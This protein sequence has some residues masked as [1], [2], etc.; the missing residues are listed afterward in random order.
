MTEKCLLVELA[1]F[2][3]GFEP[4]VE[5]W[6]T[7][8]MKNTVEVGKFSSTFNFFPQ[9]PIEKFSD[10]WQNVLWIRFESCPIVSLKTRKMRQIGRDFELWPKKLTW[11]WNGKI[12]SNLLVLCPTRLRSALATLVYKRSKAKLLKIFLTTGNYSQNFQKWMLEI[13]F[14]R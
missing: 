3:N 14:Q 11:K 4:C 10:C 12:D 8:S 9:K 5:K 6:T 2:F 7:S 1:K 13:C